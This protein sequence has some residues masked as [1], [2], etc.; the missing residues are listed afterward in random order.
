MSVQGGGWE[1]AR[2][3]PSPLPLQ[4][5]C[6]LQLADFSVFSFSFLVAQRGMSDLAYSWSSCFKVR[7]RVEGKGGIKR[8]FAIVI[9]FTHVACVSCFL[10]HFPWYFLQSWGGGTCS[11]LFFL[12][13]SCFLFL[14]FTAFPNSCGEGGREIRRFV[15][16]RGIGDCSL[17]SFII[18]FP[19]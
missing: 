5:L 15:G 8:V 7:R 2:L 6:I 12:L 13:A 16:G 3:L 11:I 10:T 19:S 17:L 9:L 14:H 18:L 4:L 1:G